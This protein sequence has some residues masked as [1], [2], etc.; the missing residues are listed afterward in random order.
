MNQTLEY[1][2]S[3]IDP[4]QVAFVFAT[5]GGSAADEVAEVVEHRTGHDGIEIE[6]A[7]GFIAD[8]VE[9]HIVNL[10]VIVYYPLR[11]GIRGQSCEQVHDCFVF[12][13]EVEF[14]ARARGTPNNVRT[15]RTAQ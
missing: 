2:Q 15:R 11:Q 14:R 13:S 8:S 7:Q 3:Q 6:H 9:Q 12:G 1:R 10:R 4:A 5:G